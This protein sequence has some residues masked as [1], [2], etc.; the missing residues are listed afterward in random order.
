VHSPPFLA[1]ALEA[2]C[3]GRVQGQP[4]DDADSV[5]LGV[6]AAGHGEPMP[7]GLWSLVRRDY[8]DVV[9]KCEHGHIVREGVPPFQ[10]LDHVLGWV[11]V[12]EHGLI[13]AEEGVHVRLWREGLR[14]RYD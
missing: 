6:V 14:R 1:L 9:G 4:Y 7:L 11:A 5:E 2:F 13:S 10:L 12:E 3:S 8:A